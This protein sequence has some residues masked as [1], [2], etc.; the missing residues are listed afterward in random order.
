MTKRQLGLLLLGAGVVGFIGIL[1]IDIIDYG[2]EGGIG[3][4]QRLALSAC[5][6]TALVGLTL[7]PLKDRP[8]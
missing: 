7:L 8:A 4:A 2:R 3:P 1:S 5:V 6:A